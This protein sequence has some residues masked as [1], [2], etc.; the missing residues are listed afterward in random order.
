[1]KIIISKLKKKFFSIYLLAFFFLILKINNQNLPNPEYDGTSLKYSI[2]INIT[3]YLK[4]LTNNKSQI[5]N[6]TIYKNQD[7]LQYRKTGIVRSTIYMS[8]ISS[9][10]MVQNYTIYNDYDGAIQGLNN[11]SIEHFVCLK[12]IAS[13][14]IKLNSENITYIID[15]TEILNNYTSICIMRKNDTKIKFQIEDYFK[16]EASTFHDMLTNW[17][18]IDEGLKNINTTISNPKENLTFMLLFN[19]PLA[20]K[21]NG[22]IKGFLPEIIYK[23][24]EKY[25][26]SLNIINGTNFKQAVSNHEVNVSIGLITGPSIYDSELTNVSIPGDLDTVSII[27]YDNS[28]N[29]TEWNIYNS[30]KDLNGKNLGVLT[31]QNETLNQLFPKTVGDKIKTYSN[32]NE[33]F[34]MLLNKEI[35][36]VLIDENILDYYEKHNNRITHFKNILTNNSYGFSFNN[37]TLRN[38][39]N[40][41]INKNYNQNSLN[42]LF[43]EWKDA[44]SN[45]I[46]SETYLNSNEKNMVLEITFPNIRPM[47]YRE[48]VTYKGYELDLLYRFAKEKG[49]RINIVPWGNNVTS[50][51][52]INIGCQ[53]IS[54]SNDIYYSYPILNSSSVLAI[55]KD[56]FRD[57]L[58][59]IVLD[60]NYKEKS[61]NNIDIP[62]EIAGVYR[63]SSC[64]FP[65][66]YNNDTIILNCT[67]SNLYLN[68]SFNGDIKYGNSSDR[69]KISYS[70]IRVDN[71]INSNIIFPGQDVLLQS[72]M[73]NISFIYGNNITNSSDT[74]TDNNDNITINRVIR[75]NSSKGGISTGGII[76]I[77]ISSV[78]VLI[79]AILIASTLS[80]KHPVHQSQPSL[81]GLKIKNLPTKTENAQI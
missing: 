72:D 33:L 49:Y 36:G 45:K 48:N 14:L 62:V 63:N 76:A 6:K 79:I 3:K 5:E 25:N 73:N 51:N 30:F 20:Y 7:D 67:I 65:D 58:S 81:Q 66:K 35:E 46:I 26:Y 56:N 18:G 68:K 53:N 64:A 52:K 21:E 55:R 60:S 77:I 80:K 15:K 54:T 47:C 23:F 28:M 24:G 75:K 70:T 59:F 41:F 57:N 10:G 4:L 61:G 13:E 22:D 31:N 9:H 69:I 16:N 1:M 12:D 27:R 32:P 74:G 50:H 29:S 43:K 71:L 8:I 44:D 40:E 19:Y 37:V 39:F 78:V 42:Q 34:F 38:E 2:A 11:Y 17:L